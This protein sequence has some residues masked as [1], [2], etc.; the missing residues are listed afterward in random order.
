[1]PLPTNKFTTLH[2]SCPSHPH[3]RH[4]PN[5]HSFTP[6]YHLRSTI[7][8]YFQFTSFTRLFHSEPSFFKHHITPSPA[9]RAMSANLQ[10]LP[11]Y[12]HHNINIFVKST[13]RTRGFPSPQ[14]LHNPNHFF[15]ID[16]LTDIS[17][18]PTSGDSLLLPS[19]LQVDL[20]FPNSSQCRARTS[21]IS[22]GSTISPITL[23]HSSNTL[24]PLSL[25]A[26]WPLGYIIVV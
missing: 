21:R 3:L 6:L 1:M 4:I 15:P 26:N 7:V 12:V 17:M 9:L 18:L 24:F 16:F 19:P 11:S 23:L 25:L 10:Q 5:S 8:L 2:Q 14:H 22:S 13:V 20:L